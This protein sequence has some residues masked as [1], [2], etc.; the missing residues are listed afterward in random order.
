MKTIKKTRHV[1]YWKRILSVIP[2]RYCEFDSQQLMIAHMAI[3]SLD[4]LGALHT[5]EDKQKIID[6]IYSLQ[7][8]P[9]KKSNNLH[10]CGFRGGDSSGECDNKNN[11]S[12]VAMTYCAIASLLIL[13]DDL[14]RVHKEACLE[15][16]KALQLSDGSF[17][18]TSAD[19]GEKDLRFV[20][21]ACCVS[22]MLDD[23][24]FIDVNKACSF[25]KSTFTYE[26]GFGQTSYNE[27][28]GGSTF[29][30]TAALKILGKL[31]EVLN[32]KE[33]QKLQNWCVWKQNNGFHGR[34]HK[35]DDTCYTFWIGGTM[36]ILG[37]TDLIDKEKVIDFVLSTQEVL[38]GG[39]SKWP[40]LNPDPLHTYTGISGLSLLGDF[41][42][43]PVD[44]ALNITNTAVNNMNSI[45]KIWKNKTKDNIEINKTNDSLTVNFR[46]LAIAVVIGISP[47]LIGK[48]YNAF[49]NQSL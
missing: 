17:K 34:P 6:W 29:C 22:K 4:V 5:V 38:V 25:I 45:H 44:P 32:Q 8:V 47:A 36:T 26:G 40:G 1:H 7:I 37:I 16:I 2:G 39:F 11:T 35:K 10:R 43:K 49:F 13:G 30:A 21:C 19:N 24:T 3:F 20:Y 31:D 9:N 28:H 15:G 23:F 42:L 18:E 12:H 48:L 27:G 33:Q 46:N 41:G 14:S